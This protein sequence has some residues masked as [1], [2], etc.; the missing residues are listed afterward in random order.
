VERL[1]DDTGGGTNTNVFDAETALLRAETD[2]YQALY[3]REVALALLRKNMGE[4]SV[5]GGGSE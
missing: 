5:T 3:D 2:A 4:W 1:R